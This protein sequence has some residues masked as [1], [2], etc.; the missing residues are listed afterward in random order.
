MHHKNSPNVA[1]AT[2]GI[3]FTSALFDKDG[4]TKCTLKELKRQLKADQA[5]RNAFA[6]QDGGE[7]HRACGCYIPI[8]QRPINQSSE[9][10]RTKVQHGLHGANLASCFHKGRTHV[11]LQGAFKVDR[12]IDHRRHGIKTEFLICWK[13]YSSK[14]DSWEPESNILDK[15][16]IDNYKEKLQR[17]MKFYQS[18]TR[19]LVWT[20]R[21]T[22][23][24]L[25]K[26]G[27][28]LQ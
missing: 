7:N 27:R 15:S 4:K 16:L 1:E 11:K 26:N 14:H 6:H 21:R 13:S 24:Y 12:I 5:C 23:R 9:T 20:R 18:P 28:G 10:I 2:N 8:N 19:D 25:K 3:N 17:N 22:R